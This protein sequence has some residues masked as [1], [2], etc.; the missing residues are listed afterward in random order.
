MGVGFLFVFSGVGGGGVVCQYVSEFVD[1]FA[2]HCQLA[3]GFSGF[4]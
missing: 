4:Q 1:D 3:F 2:K